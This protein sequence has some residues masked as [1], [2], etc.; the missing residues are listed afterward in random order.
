[1]EEGGL[2]VQIHLQLQNEFED[3]LGYMRHHLKKPETNIKTAKTTKEHSITKEF[4]VLTFE[5]TK[6]R[7]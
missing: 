4:G 5:V 7:K 6:Y 3:S 1:M 2:G